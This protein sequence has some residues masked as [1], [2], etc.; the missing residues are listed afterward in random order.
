VDS[1]AQQR[2]LVVLVHGIG[3]HRW[4]MWPL[5]RRLQQAG[6]LTHNFGYASWRSIAQTADRW[7]VRVRQVIEREKPDIV[8]VVG[9][10]MGCIVARQALAQW[11]PTEFR[12]MVMLTPPSRGT[13]TADRV[14]P[15]LGWCV[16]PVRELQTGPTSLVNL[17]PLPTYPFAVVRAARDFIIPATHVDLPA[18][19]ASLT[20]PTFH[21]TVLFHP[22]TARWV[23]DFLNDQNPGS[24]AE[25]TT[26]P[27]R[28]RPA[29]RP[30]VAAAYQATS[31]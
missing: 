13:P 12:R 19:A 25:K 22:P 6:F 26:G 18:A 29:A 14:S 28:S 20:V 24:D 11:T 9:H 10:S 3:A 17:L 4:V 21:S 30:P 27:E 16:P 23:I 2:Q 7:I 5:Q 1:V 31:I 15:Y 8:H